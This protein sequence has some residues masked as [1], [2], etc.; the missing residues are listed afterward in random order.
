[1][2]LVSNKAIFYFR[3][4]I[5]GDLENR[6]MPI[7]YRGLR[8]GQWLSGM[9]FSAAI[10]LCLAGSF[11]GASEHALFMRQDPAATPVAQVMHDGTPVSDG[12]NRWRPVALS[13][14]VAVRNEIE[15][16]DRIVIEAFTDS[17][18]TAVVDRV[19]QNVNGTVT[20]RARIDDHPLGYLLVS[21]TDG[22][23]L[24]TVMVPERNAHYHVKYDDKL[25]SHLLLDM[26]P[27]RLDKLESGPPL[28]AP[29]P[30]AVAT[31][32]SP[33]EEVAEGAML[34]APIPAGDP[35]TPATV[36][37][38]IVYTPAARSWANSSGGGIANVVAQSMERAQL[39]LDNSNIQMTMTLVYS[40]EIAYTESGSSSTDLY[41]LTFHEG[42]DPWGY[43]GAP[44]YIDH[45]HDLRAQYA[46]DLVAMFT[47]VEDTGGI[48]WLLS[49]KDGRPP[50][51]FSITRVQQAGWTYTH[52]HEMGHNMGLHHH[53]NQLDLPGKPGS[54]QPGP[55][56]WHDWPENTWSAGWRWVGNNNVRYCSV[57]TYESGAYFADGQAHSRVAYFADPNINH[58]G[59]PSGHATEGDNARTLRL[60]KP[61]V[62]G[63]RVPIGEAVD[64]DTLTWTLGGDRRWYGQ[65]TIS[66]DGV[67][68]VRNEAITHNRESWMETEVSGPG[69]L[70]FRWSVSSQANGDWLEF[71]INGSMQDR[72]SGSQGWHQ[73]SYT[74]PSGPHLLRWRYS[75]DGSV[76]HGSDCGWVDQVVWTAGPTELTVG[77][78]FA[79]FD[80]V[81]DAN[82]EAGINLNNLNLI[83]IWPGKEDVVLAPVV[84]F[85]NK[86]VGDGKTVSLTETTYLTGAD[87][88]NY[89][90]SLAGAPTATAA[91]TKRALEI[92]AASAVKV[93]D[94]TAL[95][96]AGYAITGG[97]LADGDSLD[98]VTVTGSRTDVGESANAASGARISDGESADV[99]GNY[100]LTYV[101]GA[102]EVTPAGVTVTA[103][104]RGRAYGEA[105]P[106]LTATVTGVPAE[107]TAP[108]YT[109]AT[110]A[111]A[112]SPVGPYAITVTPG[113]NPNYDVTA[114]DGMLTV[115]ARALALEGL[116]AADKVY[117]GTTDAVI[118]D[119]GEL[120][121]ILGGD[122]V[123]LNT[124]NAVA[125]FDTPEVGNNK[126]VMVAGL[127]LAG[128]DAGNYSIGSPTTTASIT[129]VTY[130][131]IFVLGEHG[132]YVSGEMEQTVAHG[133]SATAP[134]FT[135]AHGWRFESWD[136]HF[137]HV[138]SNLVIN[139]QY[140]PAEGSFAR[141]LLDNEID[142]SNNERFQQV[143]PDRNAA[144]GFVYAFGDNLPADGVL[145]RILI[146]D[147]RV[148]IEIPLQ[149]PA[150]LL[151]VDVRVV[152]IGDLLD[153]EWTV[154]VV[155]SQD[156]SGKPVD[157]VWFEIEEPF[158]GSFF[159]RLEAELK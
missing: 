54:G 57:M 27:A 53:K 20:V 120:V 111:E 133:Q 78:S 11:A 13:R 112:A 79:A 56:V 159:F 113:A 9:I 104:D 118:T 148:V 50:L 115:D 156:T 86:V 151:Y 73:K 127:L 55:T 70:S 102:L 141:W 10:R 5:L 155:E 32:P 22:R 97:M 12:A 77:G 17:V 145:L 48:G 4:L 61:F 80:K 7:P 89:T 36:N 15:T 85:E 154:P 66:Y 128:T 103:D 67:D 62:A 8:W 35:L 41:R 88:G 140:V 98:A 142:G 43:E 64:N 28:I 37:V 95:A 125:A 152:S 105:N 92:T 132:T 150:T 101:D 46:A 91:I 93:Y 59:V 122:I 47:H 29:M 3:G 45:V 117:D 158:L 65:A 126:T 60:T 39:V 1:M 107:G 130:T 51:G 119:Y 84:A 81:Y 71:C 74:L 18:Y 109:L 40:G 144:Y 157:R 87:A 69:D 82:S 149:D 30:D 137:N 21:T 139:A 23:T 24:A 52:I 100:A 116:I 31:T 124:G 25:E 143:C 63:Y 72:I 108:A 33:N 121:G 68:A 94:G 49:L 19:S 134:E 129:P 136:A 138:M 131:V 96:D 90:L 76:T 16:G 26:D 99:T 123:A 83:G 34:S 44:Y 14:S 38:M 147:G 6:I 153:S 2:P 114:V 58:Q 75:K 106:A 146:V 42:Y 135:V 110:A